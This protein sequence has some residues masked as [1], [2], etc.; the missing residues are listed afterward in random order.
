VKEHLIAEQAS[1]IVSDDRLFLDLLN[2]VLSDEGYQ[3]LYCCAGPNL[4]ALIEQTLP[5][6]IVLDSGV[7]QPEQIWERHDLVRLNPVSRHT[8]I[9]VCST[10]WR[11]LR[12]VL[13]FCC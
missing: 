7:A 6:L 9:I 12:R 3:S 1:V 5:A 8:P 10:D 2:D 4:S 11:L 13:G